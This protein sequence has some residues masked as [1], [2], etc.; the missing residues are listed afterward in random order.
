MKLSGLL[1]AT[2]LASEK[3]QPDP[4]NDPMVRLEKMKKHVQFIADQWLSDEVCKAGKKP[5]T[6]VRKI[7]GIFDR[8]ASVFNR[9]AKVT[10][11]DDP[12]GNFSLLI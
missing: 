7:T 3:K 4:L 1:V 8:M 10:D 11:G 12:E 9:C 2:A 5:E 6:Y